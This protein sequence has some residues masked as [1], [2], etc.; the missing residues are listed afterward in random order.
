[1][2]DYKCNLCPRGCGADRCNTLGFCSSGRR[3]RIARASRH[4]WEEPCISGERGSGTVFFSG[5]NLKC[6]FC[7]NEKISRGKVGIELSV[8]ELS[9][10]FL[11]INDSGVHNI[12]LVTPTHFLDVIIK[13]LEPIK[14]R[15]TVPVVYNCSGY[16]SV[17]MLGHT[18]GIIDIFLTDI[19]YK[20]N[21]LSSKY[22][23]CENY[24]DVAIRCLEE[25]IKLVGKPKMR[26]GIMVSGVIVRHLILPTHKAD[27]I[28]ILEALFERFGNKSF[29]VSLMNQY[30]PTENCSAFPALTRRV[31]SLEYK[32]VTE[33]FERLGF[34]GF[35]QEKSSSST[36]FIPDFDDTGEFLSAF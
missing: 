21:I 13:A 14:S 1:M 4:M 11:K 17:E 20:S 9:D 12:N 33:I 36:D 24:F 32:R 18:K 2:V 28:D 16:E 5:C 6:V 19:K 26:D 29:L 15:L 3:V 27:S 10:L 25:M 34:D 23:S 8:D 22:S 35:L 30:T 31:T 7:Q